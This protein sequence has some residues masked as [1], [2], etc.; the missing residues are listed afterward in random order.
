MFDGQRRAMQVQLPPLSILAVALFTN[1]QQLPTRPKIGVAQEG[2]D[3]IGLAHIGVLE[4]L[5]RIVRFPPRWNSSTS[6]ESIHIARTASLCSG[7]PMPRESEKGVRCTDGAASDGPQV[8]R[9]HDGLPGT[10]HRCSRR[11]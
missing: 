1:A 9:N 4:F 6:F 5:P 7:P 8:P 3:G 11:V 2:G 10:G